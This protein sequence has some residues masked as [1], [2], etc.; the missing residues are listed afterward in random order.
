[1]YADES[2]TIDDTYQNI[3]MNLWSAY[4]K[5]RAESKVST[6][7]YR[8]ALNTCITQLRHSSVRP[9]STSIAFDWERLPDADDDYKEQVQQLYELINQLSKLERAI[10][11]LWL[12][13]K[14]YDEISFVTGISKTNV[15]VK[16]NR[17]K[18][19]L[20]KMYNS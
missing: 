3:V 13:E 2:Q 9:R 18:E 8:I 4:P 12:D 14:S 19:K 10:I 17:I 15:G 16:I 5:F 20:K 6:W 7:I 11:M 1:M